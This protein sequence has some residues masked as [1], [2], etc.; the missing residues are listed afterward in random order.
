MNGAKSKLGPGLPK[1]TTV[2]YEAIGANVKGT[3]GGKK[4]NTS[5]AVYDKQ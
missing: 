4:K 1:N 5:T 3:V 2:V